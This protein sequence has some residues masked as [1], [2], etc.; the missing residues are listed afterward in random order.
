MMNAWFVNTGYVWLDI[1]VWVICG[2]GVILCTI[3]L[4]GYYRDTVWPIHQA[5]IE[6]QRRLNEQ[7]D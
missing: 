1:L 7:G 5:M 3:G 2:I 6:E 4:R